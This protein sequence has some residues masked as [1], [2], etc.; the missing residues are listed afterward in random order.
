MSQNETVAMLI[1]EAVLAATHP[2][3]LALRQAERFLADRS[4]PKPPP[5]ARRKLAQAEAVAAATA[6]T[7]MLRRHRIGVSEACR[8]AKV[9]ADPNQ[10]YKYALTAREMDD[11]GTLVAPL[12]VGRPVHKGLAAYAAMAKA[13][14]AKA[15]VAE[16]DLLEELGGALADY[17]APF[18]P[19]R[20]DPYERLAANLSML[21]PFLGRVQK[22][23]DGEP[24]D[25]PE[26]L[27]FLVREDLAW[28]PGRRTL[29]PAHEEEV[30]DSAFWE[31]LRVP[32]F[33]RRVGRAEVETI[34]YDADASD[35]D[36]VRPQP[37]GAREAVIL[38]VVWLGIVRERGLRAVLFADPWTAVASAPSTE[39]EPAERF[40]FASGVPFRHT[41]TMR[42]GD[43]D[44]GVELGS[45]LEITCPV[46]RTHVEA[47]ADKGDTGRLFSRLAYSD[48]QVSRKLRIDADTLRELV[49]PGED[50]RWRR[51]LLNAQPWP[52]VPG[53]AVPEALPDA[54]GADAPLLERIE[55]ALLGD[56]L[57]I[58]SAF[59]GELSDR[60]RA[61]DAHLAR[62]RR[63]RRLPDARFRRL[64]RS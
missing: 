48:L 29:V 22:A 39:T 34:R 57:A 27:R 62:T 28:A 19:E 2:N 10:T 31:A 20:A 14:A 4:K 15:G 33:V 63:D 6:V 54:D 1:K 35:E 11:A 59:L 18:A 30:L 45:E 3:A 42:D 8:A 16:D 9:T 53:F 38:E 13:I 26:F 5:G 58:V 60:M 44:L 17:L 64:M 46:Y 32:L 61:M 56:D 41:L 47:T 23:T 51:A 43:G 40:V 21:A 12:R 24:V 36:A 49:E 7:R 25:Y 52:Y 55:H 50:V 37:L